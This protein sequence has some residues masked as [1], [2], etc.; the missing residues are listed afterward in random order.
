MDLKQI[1]EER[2]KDAGILLAAGQWGGAYYLAGYAVECGL[3]ACII[4]NIERTGALFED[5][6][7]AEKCFTHDFSKLLDA[8]GLIAERDAKG[9][10]DL[11]FEVNW[12]IVE[13]WKERERYYPKTEVQ[14]RS[15]IEAITHPTSGILPW[16]KA[17]W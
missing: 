12:S 8:S 4:R 14:A 5:R 11:N 9:A 15:L 1:A 6:K 2:L 3:K 17:H 7:F 10:S 13:Q 16:L